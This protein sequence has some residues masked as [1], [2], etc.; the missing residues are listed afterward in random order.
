MPDTARAQK[1]IDG[2]VWKVASNLPRQNHLHNEMKLFAIKVHLPQ[3]ER[4]NFGPFEN[5]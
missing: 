3:Y 1:E 5:F 4:P 2:D